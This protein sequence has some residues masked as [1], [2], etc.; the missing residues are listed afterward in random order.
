MSAENKGLAEFLRSLSLVEQS[1]L[2]FRFVSFPMQL[3][4]RAKGV[5]RWYGK[6][7][8]VSENLHDLIWPRLKKL[9]FI[10]WGLTGPAFTDL[11]L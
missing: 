8:N 5:R 11:M 3:D 6:V 4:I 1:D 7:P 9:K 10:G 2:G